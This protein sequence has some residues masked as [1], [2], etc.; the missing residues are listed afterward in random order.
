MT[1]VEKTWQAAG[2]TEPESAQAVSSNPL[3]TMGN[4]QRDSVSSAASTAHDTQKLEH[5]PSDGLKSNSETGTLAQAPS[6]TQDEEHAGKTP[7]NEKLSPYDQANKSYQSSAEELPGSTHLQRFVDERIKALKEADVQ[8]SKPLGVIWKELSVQGM[9]STKTFVHSVDRA[10]LGTFGPNVWHFIS[11][12]V[13]Q[14]PAMIPGLHPPPVRNLIQGFSGVLEPEMCLVLGK[15]GAGCTTFLRALSNQRGNFVSVKGEVSYGG[16]D[17][18]TIN[19]NFRGEVIFTD[20]ADIHFPSLTVGQTLRFALRNKI[21]RYRPANETRGDFKETMLNII[22]KMF[23]IE[24]TI[25]TPVGGPGAPGVSGGERKRTSIA[26]ALVAR[27]TVA[28]WDQSTRGLDSAT[29]LDYIKS[30]RV[31]TDTVQ[32]TNI[33]TLY[34]ASEDIYNLFDK[35]LLIDEGRCIYFGPATEAKAY[36][37]D[38]G[39]FFPHRQTSADALTSVT[40]FEEVRYREGWEGK[41]PKTPIAR[42]RAFLESAQHKEN[43]RLIAAREQSFVED[44]YRK[45]T[46]NRVAR[47]EKAKRQFKKSSYTVSFATNVKSL[48]IRQAQIKWGDRQSFYTKTFTC[49]TVALVVSA[50]FYSVDKQNT[51]ASLFTR[52]GALFFSLL[53]LGWLNLSEIYEA[54]Q[55]RPIIQRHKAFGFYSPAA[56]SIARTVI[57]LPINAFLVVLFSLISYFMCGFQRT[58]SQ[59]FIYLLIVFSSV[60]NLTAYFRAIAA[61]SPNF[62]TAIRFAVL[63]LNVAV[64]TVGYVIPRSLMPVGI[65]WI[66]YIHPI[67]YTFEALMGNEFAGTDFDCTAQL[68]PQVA[69]TTIANQVCPIAGAVPGQPFVAGSAYIEASYG[70]SRSNLWRNFGISLAFTAVYI[71]AGA[72]FSQFLDYSNSGGS[73]TVFARTKRAKAAVAAEAKPDDEEKGFVGGRMTGHRTSKSETG[74]VKG[75]DASPSIFTF[76][77][78]CYTVQT[79]AGPRQLLNKVSGWAKPG[80]S[81]ALMGASGAGKTTLLNTLAGRH[82]PMQIT[83]DIKVDG[84]PLGPSFARDIGFAEQMDL[85]DPTQTVREAL[86]F[87][88]LLRQPAETPKQ[89]KLDHVNM[90]I[91]LL[92]LEDLEDAIIGTVEN[93]LSVE[94]K[95]RVTIGVELAAKPRVMQFM[96]EPTSGLSSEGAL[97]IGRF[98]QRLALSGQ[99]SFVVCHQPSSLLFTNYF[100]RLLLLAPGGRTCYHGEVSDIKAYFEG[101]GSRKCGEEENLA[102]FAVD[103]VSRKGPK[104]VAWPDIW[105]QSDE[106]RQ[107]LRQIEEI[108]AERSKLPDETPENLLRPYATSTR[109]QTALLTKRTVI[110]LWR[111]AAYGYSK[112]SAIVVVSLFNA[113]TFIKI[114]EGPLS[115]AQ[116]QQ[117]VF[118][119]FLIILILPALLNSSIPKAFIIK[120]YWM[121]R[122]GPSRTYSWLPLCNAIML[123]ELPYAIAGGIL[124]WV[125]WY[126]IVAFGTGEP[127]GYSLLMNVLLLIFVYTLAHWLC[128]LAMSPT[129]VAN[130][131]PFMLVVLSLMNGV[132]VQYEVLPSPYK[133]FLYWANP[134]QWWIRGSISVLMHDK[135][136]VCQ[137]SEFFAFSPPQGQTCGSY[138]GAY[139][140]SVMGN[141]TNPDATKDCTY[142]QYTVADTFAASLNAYHDQRWRYF[143]LFLVFVSTNVMIFYAAFYAFQVKFLGSKLTLGNVLGLFKRKNKGKAGASV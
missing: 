117:S 64:V 113:L 132:I 76:R 39:F 37:R 31:L 138:A 54:C 124:Y 55:G 20:E 99:T 51:T 135:Q 74:K 104:G 119:I 84:R 32:T 58:A 24:H 47:A 40:D 6:P 120:S 103:V 16:V 49:V 71:I 9:G 52:G 114:G 122:E 134:V 59:F 125:L 95:K 81:T 83:G 18:Q 136:V 63:S 91:K 14:L 46:L 92:A 100:D 1:D 45:Q 61:L 30:L 15:P 112:V 107:V 129:L 79:P 25:N 22:L 75:V 88:A 29:A 72:V 94:E 93:G 105:V 73:V 23:A 86:E 69:G 130:M 115:V 4:G 42:E 65:R 110:A 98:I 97:Q 133:K 27:A 36:F 35:V 3:A 109:T 123:A 131:L 96:D 102:E 44:D 68:V 106:Y 137:P 90:V 21:P 128:A 62:D 7:D 70:F 121:L 111:D 87:S 56:V 12:L 142:C 89:D 85:H 140:S 34:Q 28:A 127:A 13:P 48:I 78:V 50:M 26:E 10:I 17:H 33:V 57:D 126:W 143:G 41:A 43:L 116:L 108:E 53:F 139:I 38:L 77:D 66:S 2:D 60:L 67:S 80:T 118:T 8:F 82:N 101:K 5:T 141:L 11:K 19:K